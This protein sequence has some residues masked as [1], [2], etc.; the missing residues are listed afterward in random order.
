[1]WGQLESEHLANI[2]RA[3]GTASTEPPSGLYILKKTGTIN[4]QHN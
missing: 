3:H 2:S 4:V 1:M